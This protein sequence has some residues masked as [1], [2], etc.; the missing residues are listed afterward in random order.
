M[1]E[2]EYCGDHEFNVDVLTY[3]DHR[4]EIQINDWVSG[5][6]RVI[7]FYDFSF[8]ACHFGSWQLLHRMAGIFIIHW[9]VI[10]DINCLLDSTYKMGGA[11][12][13]QALMEKFADVILA[14]GFGLKL[15]GARF[16]WERECE[17]DQWILE[18]LDMCFD[19]VAWGDQFPNHSLMNLTVGYSD[20]SHN[21]LECAVPIRE[22]RRYF[23]FEEA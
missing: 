1:S 13:P 8:R 10:G 11:P 22:A 17:T 18:K 20:H 5:S 3:S 7:G 23:R 4:I 12:Y 14:L 19:Y 15:R 2:V 16:T 21:F 9:V 6:W